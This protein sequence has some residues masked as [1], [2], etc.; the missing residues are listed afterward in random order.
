MGGSSFL[1]NKKFHPG[2]QDNQKRV[3]VAEQNHADKKKR[4][5]EAA[6]EVLKEA[7]ISYYENLGEI[8]SRDPRNSSLKFMY[9]MPLKKGDDDTKRVAMTSNSGI[10]ATGEDDDMVKKFWSQM[11]DFKESKKRKSDPS[12]S[13]SS[14]NA[15]ANN[16]NTNSNSNSNGLSQGDDYYAQHRD[17]SN[18]G[19]RALRDP[20]DPSKGKELHPMLRNAPVE[21]TYVKNMAKVMYKPFND[22]IRNI[23]CSRCGEW[24]HRFG[25]RECALRD[26]NPHDYARQQR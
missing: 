20:K 6:Q 18:Q 3:F 21:G 26:Y 9:S 25:D 4:E 16:F 8:Q 12:S 7:E 23:Q 17:S 10:L 14:S 22:V 15:F 1:L 13:S 19:Q 24:G 5:D 11:D 2:R